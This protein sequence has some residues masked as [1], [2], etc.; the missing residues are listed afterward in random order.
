MIIFAKQT[1]LQ[2]VPR[3]KSGQNIMTFLHPSLVIFFFHLREKTNKHKVL[4]LI[5][6]FSISLSCQLAEFTREAESS[7]GEP[8]SSHETD[9]DVEG[10]PDI[11]GMQKGM[12]PE[13]GSRKGY[14]T[15]H[16]R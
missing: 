3:L 1:N 8:R 10:F 9:E 16:Q 5:I 15:G 4:E 6:L 11:N 2:G 14:I 12:F 7:Q 13:P